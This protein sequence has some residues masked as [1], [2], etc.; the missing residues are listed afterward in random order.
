M[1]VRPCAGR[2]KLFWDNHLI[3][4]ARMSPP[5]SGG[6]AISPAVAGVSVVLSLHEVYALMELAE[7]APLESEFS[8]TKGLAFSGWFRYAVSNFSLNRLKAQASP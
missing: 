4:L 6:V 5:T 3:A 2:W 7:L 8:F 1:S